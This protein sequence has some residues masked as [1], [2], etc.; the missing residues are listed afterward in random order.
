MSVSKSKTEFIEYKFGRR[1]Q[2]V[3]EMWRA[4]TVSGEV[5]GEAESFENKGV[6]AL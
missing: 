1:N 4:V 5:I 2:D 3:G 6:E